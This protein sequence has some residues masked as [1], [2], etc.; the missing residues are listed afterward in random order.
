MSTPTVKD[1][2]S[3]MISSALSAVKANRLDTACDW[4]NQAVQ[5]ISKSDDIGLRTQVNSTLSVILM[6]AAVDTRTK[7]LRGA[8]IFAALDANVQVI[9]RCS[10]LLT[11]MAVGTDR[12]LG[13]AIALVIGGY[14]KQLSASLAPHKTSAFVHTDA[15]KLDEF[16]N[17]LNELIK[18]IKTYTAGASTD[19]PEDVSAADRRKLAATA[20]SNA[21]HSL[22][23]LFPKKLSDWDKARVLAR[24]ALALVEE[25]HANLKDRFASA[26]RA[27]QSND[28]GQ[29]SAVLQ[30]IETSLG[31]CD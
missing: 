11:G 22:S 31:G 27:L 12:E 28:Y 7:A 21:R 16:L 30:S 8:A 13:H 5:A 25:S 14:G 18:A 3:T 15:A 23:R 1:S 29:S 2:L 17:T 19:N 24:H 6:A 4:A 26:D 9:E 10:T 20:V